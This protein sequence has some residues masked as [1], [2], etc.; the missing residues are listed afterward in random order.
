[1]ITQLFVVWKALISEKN[2]LTRSPVAS[3]CLCVVGAMGALNISALLN[4]IKTSQPAQFAAR[5][6]IAAIVIVP[7]KHFGTEVALLF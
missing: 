5:R 7:R 2:A 3:I 6:Q 1:M 4:I